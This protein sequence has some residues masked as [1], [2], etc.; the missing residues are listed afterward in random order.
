[1]VT[2]ESFDASINCTFL[3]TDRLAFGLVLISCIDDFV[4]KIS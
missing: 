2:V 1:M 3:E 4:L